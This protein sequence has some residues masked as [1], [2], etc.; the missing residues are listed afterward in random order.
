MIK[1][2]FK[3]FV[4]F[5]AFVAVGAVT[6]FLVLKV[7]NFDRSGEVPLLVGK[8]VT[9]AAELLNRRKLFL[10]VE[11]KKY[12]DEIPEGYIVKQ[13]IDPGEKVQIGTEVGVIVSKGPEMYSMP[14][15]EGQ[16][17][18]DAKL[19]L[20]NL[21]IKLNKVTWVHSDT[22]E[23]GNII[24]Q[25][26]LP[27]NRE[28]NE[29]NFLVSLGP[30]NVSYRCPSFVNMTV[31]DARILARELGIKLLERK[32]GSRVIFQ[33]PEEGAIIN[34]GDTVEVTLGRGWGMWF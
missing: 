34:K 16:P 22:V 11:G 13:N 8:S 15:F 25:R 23:K 12:H 4:Y 10:T 7:I 2:Y 14:S 33:K 18:E 26:P 5:I 19:T 30:Y 9:E 1:T 32:T 27:G 31:E 29:I 21:G 24:A 28:S 20:I 17:L 6:T 3:L